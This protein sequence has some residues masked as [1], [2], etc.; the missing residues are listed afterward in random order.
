M[1]H[2]NR[3]WLFRKTWPVT[4]CVVT[5]F[6]VT[7]WYIFFHWCNRTTVIGKKNVPYQDNTLLLSNHQSM[8]DSFLVGLS[9]VYP[10]S[11]RRPSLLP[12]NPAAEENFYSNPVLAWFSDNWKCIPVK[13]GRKDVRAIFKMAE[14]LK[15]GIM[16]L[17]PEGTRSRDGTIRQG[18]AGAGYLILETKA[19]VVPVCIDGMDKVLPIGSTFPRMFKRI[20]VYYG[21]PLDFSD[22]FEGK[23]SKEKA[24]K[25]M[26]IVMER[27]REMQGELKEFQHGGQVLK[28]EDGFTAST[29]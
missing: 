24:Q 11:V 7:L 26:E 5:N 1:F 25:V 21:E 23:R 18:R 13:E 17:F 29:P 19:T 4:H 28:Q 27:I 9:A 12:W 6:T 20:Y 8:V 15:T 10:A 3:G 16:T 14:A 2:K 22:Y